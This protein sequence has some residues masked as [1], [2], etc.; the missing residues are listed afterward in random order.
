ML[1]SFAANSQLSSDTSTSIR[2]LISKKS[3]PGSAT[4]IKSRSA[5]AVPTRPLATAK[6]SSMSPTP[7]TNRLL[8]PESLDHPCKLMLSASTKMSQSRSST[9]TAKTCVA[10]TLSLR[11]SSSGKRISASAAILFS[12]MLTL[13]PG[14]V[15]NCGPSLPGRI[16]RNSIS[17]PMTSIVTGESD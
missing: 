14:T 7:D 1:N 16:R 10:E 6:A 3:L 5:V 13:T 12:S 2:P 17:S 11:P 15:K 4:S 8:P 9:G